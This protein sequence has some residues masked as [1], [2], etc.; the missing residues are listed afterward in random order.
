MATLFKVHF[1]LTSPTMP[2]FLSFPKP[3]MK[4]K[5]PFQ[6]ASQNL[7]DKWYTWIFFLLKSIVLINFFLWSAYHTVFQVNLC[8]RHLLREASLRHLRLEGKLQ[9]FVIQIDKIVCVFLPHHRQL[10]RNER[11]CWQLC[12]STRHV[13]WHSG[14]QS[15]PR[16]KHYN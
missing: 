6:V 16:T 4:Q 8:Q 7:L 5:K 3:S 11:L 15:I 1:S 14:W 10:D 13:S 9:V 2:W 12:P